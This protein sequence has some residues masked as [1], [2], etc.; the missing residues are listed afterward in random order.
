[1]LEDC[2]ET[3]DI[4]I[5]DD[6]LFKLMKMAHEKDITFNKFVEEAL[7]VAIAQIEE[8]KVIALNY[9]SEA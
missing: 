9:A 5:D 1:M 8:D 4:D 3:I 7:R 2:R 6:T